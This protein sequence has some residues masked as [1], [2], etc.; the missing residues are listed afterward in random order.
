MD[1]QKREMDIQEED[2]DIKKEIVNTQRETAGIEEKDIHDANILKKD[3]GFADLTEKVKSRRC[4][5]EKIPPTQEKTTLLLRTPSIINA[6][7]ASL[8]LERKIFI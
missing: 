4:C 5:S 6:N 7:M 3:V 2:V 1:D 8:I